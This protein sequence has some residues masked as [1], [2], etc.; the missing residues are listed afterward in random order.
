MAGEFGLFNYP[1]P[2]EIRASIGKTQLE[3]AQAAG[4]M[5][6]GRGGVVVS[7]LAGQRLGK[8]LRSLFGIESPEEKKALKWE[9]INKQIA[10]SEFSMEDD[11]VKFLK[12]VGSTFQKNEMLPQALAAFTKAKEFELLDAKAAKA[13]AGTGK[14]SVIAQLQ[15]DRDKAE[16]EGRS[17]DASAISR[18]IVKEEYIADNKW[19]KVL[20]PL[21][22]KIDKGVKFSGTDIAKIQ[23]MQ[24]FKD[25]PITHEMRK[26]LDTVKKQVGAINL[27]IGATNII[28]LDR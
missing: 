5:S 8:G 26:A 1:T 13:R 17:K 19:R 4:G 21:L 7:S 3:R 25:Q 27:N 28:D 11:P 24:L 6:R 23:T 2:E 10:A 14:K 16:A 9:G 18:R 15:F 12:H 20:S 22:R